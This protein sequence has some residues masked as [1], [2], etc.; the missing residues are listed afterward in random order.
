[1]SLKCQVISVVKPASW[2]PHGIWLSRSEFS[3]YFLPPKAVGLNG[4]KEFKAQSESPTNKSNQ[5][6]RPREASLFSALSGSKDGV[7]FTIPL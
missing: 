4:K 7:R 1:M 3:Q 5:D 6:R 2:Q